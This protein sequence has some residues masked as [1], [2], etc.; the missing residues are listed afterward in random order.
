MARKRKPDGRKKKKPLPP[1]VLRYLIVCEDS[2]SSCDYLNRFPYDPELVELDFVPGAGCHRTVVEVAIREAEASGPYN[3]VYCVLD[4]DMPKEDPNNKIAENYRA[5]F[6]LVKERTDFTVIWGND[7]FELWYV[8]HFQYLQSPT[9]RDGLYSLLDKHL[10]RK[11]DKADRQLFDELAPI[12]SRAHGHAE[13]LETQYVMEPMP[14][15]INPSTNIHNLI[16][17]L[18]NLPPPPN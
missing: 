9:H 1:E 5:A 6:D 8:F 15:M 14:W 2:K 17:V 18:E 10:G 12:R 3:H 13:R 7:C 4:R 11:Y 16:R